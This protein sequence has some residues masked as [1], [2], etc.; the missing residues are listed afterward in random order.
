[1][2]TIATINNLTHRE[3]T[4]EDAYHEQLLVNDELAYYYFNNDYSTL[5]FGYKES[6][7]LLGGLISRD[8]IIRMA[9]SMEYIE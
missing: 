1:M 7:F 9:E 2:I 3:R 4:S 5:L 8:E 6:K